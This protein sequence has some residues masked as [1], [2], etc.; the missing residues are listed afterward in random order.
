VDWRLKKRELR[1]EW[2]I[3]SGLPVERRPRFRWSFLG[4]RMGLKWV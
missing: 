4:T 1:G 3:G 2:N